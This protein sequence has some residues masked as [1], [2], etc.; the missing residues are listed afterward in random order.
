[1]SEFLHAAFG[2]PAALFSA[3]LIVVV[4]FWLMVLLGGVEHDSFDGHIDGGLLGAGGVPV[5]VGASLFI[6]VVWFASLTGSIL[7]GRLSLGGA[8]GSVIVLVLALLIARIVTGILVRP[9]RRLF[10]T[11]ESPPSR[12]DFIGLTCVIR[13][14]RV[15]G[16]FGQAEVAAAD[17]ST[18]V[19]QVRQTGTDPLSYGHT[20]LLY[21]YDEP[22]EFFW[23]APYDSALD[24]RTTG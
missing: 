24:P 13:T 3:A 16:V 7:L 6:T 1:M 18:A 22:G 10:R 15:D 2:F 8:A 12:L 19:V 9:L 23:V 4:A 11:G 5:T 14:G 21:A 17:G 20:G